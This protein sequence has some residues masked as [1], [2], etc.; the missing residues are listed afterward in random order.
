MR[1]AQISRDT[2]ETRIR[3]SLNLDGEGNSTIA[4][5]I[6]FF[7]HML[8]HLSKHGG[9]DLD[10]SAEGDLEIDAH[11]TVE[12]VGICL[13][14]AFL[15]AV[16]SPE[17]LTRFGH[18]VLPM[19][20]SLAEVAVDFSGRPYLVYRAKLPQ[21][22]VGEF[23]AELAEEFFRAFA[24]NGRINLHVILRYGTNLHH[25]IEVMFKTFAKALSRALALDPNSSG[26]PSTK[27]V[28]ET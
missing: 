22:S 6:G 12:D 15:K 16:G 10:V 25:G 28:I 2:K 11:H 24:M 8:T 14:Q 23:D 13:G 1:S 21:S 3:V 17:G 27:G 18:A 20:D 19:D 9:F 4:T 7:D 26:I 5:G